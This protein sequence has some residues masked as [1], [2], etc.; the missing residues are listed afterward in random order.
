MKKK[1]L[2][3]ALAFA[4]L[5]GSASAL[6]QEA[7]T[8]SAAITASAAGETSGMCGGELSWSLSGGVLT[9]SGDDYMYDYTRG[10]S[11]FQNRTDIKSV[12]IS[13]GVKN[14]G[15]YAFSGCTAITGVTI[16]DSIQ[17]INPY[18]FSN[19]TGLK[20]ITIPDSVAVIGSYAFSSSGL[21][22]V[23]IPSSVTT[24]EDSTF[25]ACSSLSSVTI[26][27]SVKKLDT[28]AFAS[29]SSLKD[30]PV[31]KG[32]TTLGDYAFCNCDALTDIT[33]PSSVTSL[34]TGV[35][36]GCDEI[37]SAVI[38]NSI[39]SIGARTFE[40]CK[41]LSSANI[42]GSVT[43]IGSYAF[44][45]CTIKS[46]TLPSGLK[47]IG[48]HAFCATPLTAV[49]IPNSV[50]S[51]GNYA[52]SSCSKLTTI[53]IP[54]SVT[55]IPKGMLEYCY[56]ITSITI[57]GS[58]KTI[59]EWAFHDCNALSKI[60]IQS[61]VTT[62]GNN[63]FFGCTAI[64][65]ITL[66][67]SVKTI[68]NSAFYK[69]RGLTGI[70]IPSSVTS[71][72]E[73][74]FSDCTALKSITI[75][76]SVKTIG[77]SAFAKSTALK[78]ITIPKSVTA[79]AESTF[80]GCTGLTSVTI[81]GSVTAIKSSAFEGCTRI[82]Q[83]TIPSGVKTIGD[84]AFY[85][86]SGI[87]SVAVPGTVT[88]IGKEAFSGC[89]GLYRV[90]IP[91]SVTT[92]GEQAF[93]NCTN[94]KGV[95]IPKTVNRIGSKAFGFDKNG[96][97]SGFI[98]TCYPN[99]AGMNY[100]TS[101]GLKYVQ[102]SSSH[103]HTYAHTVVSAT[104]NERGFTVH[105]CKTCNYTYLD[106]YTAIKPNAHKYGSWA[107]AKSASPGVNGTM[108][109]TCS[110][111]GGVST[112]KYVY[113]SRLYGSTRYA[114]AASIADRVRKVNGDTDTVILVN[115]E[116]FA[117]ALAG[118]PYAYLKNAPILLVPNPKDANHYSG[119]SD[120]IIEMIKLGTKNVIILGGNSSVSKEKV[121]DVLKKQGKNVTRIAGAT[122]YQTAAKIAETVNPNPS[123]VFIVYSQKFPDA[124]S[125]SSIAAQK[126]APILYVDKTG[127]I[128]KYTKAYLTKHKSTIKK[129]Y[130][131]GGTGAISNNVKSQIDKTLGITS[132][133][134]KG[135]TRYETCLAVLNYS[136]FKSFVNGTDLC[137]STG[138]KFPD[139]LA[140]GV[141]AAM[142]KGPVMLVN[143]KTSSLTLTDAQKAFLKA[144]TTETITVLGGKG[145]VPSNHVRTISIASA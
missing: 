136:G 6:P 1:L 130:V 102:Y 62:I 83:I 37:K 64:T 51:I 49:S 125:I 15:K 71:I 86:C 106:T 85:N 76:T 24:I 19:C 141:L 105:R 112:T 69:C 120:A 98:A 41:K 92:V 2:S 70:T 52:F 111:C 80:S 132:T 118:V 93:Y 108:S 23:T 31:M 8:D 79:I 126:K 5:L 133:R 124:L 131:I 128:D 90:T 42:P 78:S 109:R 11:P 20:N 60:T 145:A 72:G 32:V 7:F 97:L 144:R 55:A 54:S 84:K 94:L 143:G 138:E 39:K 43:S 38:P 99:S 45:C 63:A 91:A 16:P 89:S 47:T 129:A 123:E 26:P 121:E 137:V 77:K 134:I 28:Y 75:P 142:T 53:N 139:A 4:V 40:N 29:C 73:S 22:S 46:I 74:A 58:I 119:F 34:G 48:D 12:V 44:Y 18:A 14:I 13:P 30:L 50:T 61:G 17:T 135:S 87:R 10:T 27:D 104:C 95:T 25:A 114:T 82:S 113:F 122:R 107:V 68:G 36:S 57:P 117:D 127:T 9:I 59:G 66:P 110:L 67:S 101:N 100:V 88:I 65:G 96:K 103:K 56:A 33:I 81:P 3:F 116:K 115:S 21:V 140:G 35:F